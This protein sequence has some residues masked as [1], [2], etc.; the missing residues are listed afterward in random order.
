MNAIQTISLIGVMLLFDSIWLGFNKH[1]Y[2]KW[3]APT[4]QHIKIDY[5]AVIACYL[6]LFFVG[7]VMLCVPMIKQDKSSSLPIW[8]AFR[9]AGLVGFV[10]YATFNLVNKAIFR[11][12][13]WTMVIVDTLWGTLVFTILGFIYVYSGFSKK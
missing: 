2:Q 9:W 6:V 4:Q 8:K 1:T 10:A 7:F 11:D 12:Y 5:V 3:L 13:P